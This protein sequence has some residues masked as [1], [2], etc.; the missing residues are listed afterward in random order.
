M[1]TGKATQF[2]CSS[3]F[4]ICKVLRMISAPFFLPEIETQYK[5]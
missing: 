5:W 1:Y 3:V 2:F 4:P